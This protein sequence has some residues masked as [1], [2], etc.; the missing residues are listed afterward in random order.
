MANWPLPQRERW[1]GSVL[2]PLQHRDSTLN[3][4]PN[5]VSLSA[6]TTPVFRWHA[7]CQLQSVTGSQLSKISRQGKLA[8]AWARVATSVIQNVLCVALHIDSMRCSEHNIAMTIMTAAIK[9][10]LTRGMA[11][12]PAT[13]N[14]H[15]SLFGKASKPSMSVGVSQLLC[16]SYHLHQVHHCQGRCRAA[17][18]CTARYIAEVG[19]EA[20]PAPPQYE[21]GQ[22]KGSPMPVCLF[23]WNN[24]PT[25]LASSRWISIKST[26]TL[27]I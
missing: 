4:G 21:D 16:R 24:R 17:D 22:S 14:L 19:R 2:R 7:L 10:V 1:G 13:K 3:Q 26:Q 9:L 12:S 23:L 6:S 11:T 27:L 20:I 5:S 25:H 18:C 15:T 8:R